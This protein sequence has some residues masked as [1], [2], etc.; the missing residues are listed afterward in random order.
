MKFTR[1]SLIGSILALPFLSKIAIAKPLSLPKL[2]PR[3]RQ[4]FDTP[5]EIGLTSPH[6]RDLRYGVSLESSFCDFTSFREF[7]L[8]E[9]V[10][11]HIHGK[12]VFSGR[13]ISFEVTSPHQNLIIY[14]VHAEGM[15]YGDYRS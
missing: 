3:Q 2:H 15:P 14:K 6:T 13:V 4:L 12:R 5:T 11:V 8:E 9:K 7:R 10:E 1:R